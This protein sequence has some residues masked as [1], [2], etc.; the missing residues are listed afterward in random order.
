MSAHDV[1]PLPF[2]PQAVLFDMDGLILDS[3]RVLLACWRQANAEL[4]AGLDD[5]LWLSMV[6]IHE[7]ACRDMVHARLPAERAEAL[8]ERTNA[9]YEAR[10][11]TGLPLKR[12]LVAMLDWL[13][14]RAIPRAIATST[15]RGRAEAKLCAAGVRDRFDVLVT[16]SDVAHPK[17][18]PDIYVLAAA[19]LGVEPE[20]CV[21]LEDSLPGV[22]AALAAG[23]VPVQV[24]DLVAPDAGAAHRVV[25]DLERALALLQA[26]FAPVP[27]RP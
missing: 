2:A 20:A 8:I 27:A 16:G 12:G 21:V 3:E 17:P 9:L 4:G 7:A 1:A 23:A 14:A 11:A 26:A 5:A 22:R 24:P 19:S 15:V 13:D 25:A 10:V 18:A 6:G